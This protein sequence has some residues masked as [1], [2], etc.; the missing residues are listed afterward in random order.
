M[1]R[2]APEGQLISEIGVIETTESDNILRWDGDNLYVEQDVFHNGQLVHRKYR[3]R[4]TKQV[5]QAIAKMLAQ[6]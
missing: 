6:H 5:A 1:S 4:V 3:R 2:A